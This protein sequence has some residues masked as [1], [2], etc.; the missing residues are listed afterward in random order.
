MFVLTGGAATELYVCHPASAWTK[1]GSSASGGG[2]LPSGAVF[3]ITSGTCPA[4]TTEATDLAGKTLL[5][6]LAANA[7][8]GTTGGVD[9]LTPQ[10][11]VSQPTL[12]MNAYTPAGTNG[13]ATF[14]PTGTISWPAGVPIFTGSASSVVVNHVHTLATGTGST[15]SFAQVIGTVDTSSGGTGATPTQTALGTRSGNPVA[16]GAASYTP[17]GTLA[18]PVG[19]PTFGGAQGTVPAETFTGTP[20]TLTGSVSQPTFTGTAFDNRSAF[21][22]VIFCRVS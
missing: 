20:A 22:K 8:V 2:G 13:T 7:D 6:T 3:F 14:T 9:S 5:G 4:G 17:E 12:T 15:G 16:G 18:W 10:G 19:V 21:T 11:T 1:V